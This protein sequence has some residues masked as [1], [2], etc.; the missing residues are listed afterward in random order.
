[1]VDSQRFLASFRAIREDRGVFY[2]REAAW[3][4]FNVSLRLRFEG[5]THREDVPGALEEGPRCRWTVACRAV[6]R[7]RICGHEI[8][9]LDFPAAHPVLWQ[10]DTQAK[11]LSFAGRPRD[12]EALLG[13]LYRAHQRLTRGQIPFLAHLN[14]GSEEALLALLET[15]SGVLA[16]GPEELLRQYAAELTRQGC[17]PGVLGGEG[18]PIVDPAWRYS[19][20][21][22]LAWESSYVLAEEFLFLEEDPR[23]ER[24]GA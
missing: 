10:F 13:A 18:S 1:M 24:G 17:E 15:G 11:S 7:C 5:C 19:G 20:Y 6:E 4:R 12:P 23:L 9:S 22:V 8:Y 16:R 14:A 21:A 2:L 3:D